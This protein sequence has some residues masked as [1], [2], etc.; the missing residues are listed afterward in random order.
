MDSSILLYDNGG[1]T[2]P[3]K[4]G[5]GI[6][7]RQIDRV[8]EW[9]KLGLCPEYEGR[10]AAESELERDY[11]S[12]TALPAVQGKEAEKLAVDYL[13]SL[14]KRVDEHF[15]ANFDKLVDEIPRQ[16]IVTVPAIWGHKEQD[17]TR[18]CAERAGMGKGSS[19]QVVS[20]PEAAA[21]YAL[22]R[23]PRVGLGIGDTFIICDAGGG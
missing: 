6:D 14:K 22:E 13:S 17:R 20:E 2:G 9:F 23:M 15:A 5:F 8:H 11:R 4:W 3:F 7:K 21:I 16:Y 10:R 18:R 19:L 12:S 1:T